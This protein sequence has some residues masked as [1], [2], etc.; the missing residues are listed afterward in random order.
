LPRIR[1]LEISLQACQKFDRSGRIGANPAIVNLLDR[2]CIQAVPAKPPLG[3]DDDHFGALEHT[4]VLH[5]RAAVQPGKPVA[6]LARVSGR[7]PQQVENAAAR[8]MAERL[9][10]TVLLVEAEEHVILI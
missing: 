2:H 3:P 8:R 4:E 1:I 6:Q 7:I 10:D 9:E 5:D